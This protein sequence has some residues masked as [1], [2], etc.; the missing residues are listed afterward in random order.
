MKTTIQSENKVTLY[1]ATHNK[2]G[3]KYFG[4][5]TRYFTEEDLQKYYHGSGKYWLRHLYKHGDDITMEIYGIYNLNEVKEEAL[6]LSK[7]WDIVESKDWANLKYEDGLNGGGNII[8]DEGK[9][10]ISLANSDKLIVINEEGKNIKISTS[11]EKYING[12]YESVN[13]GKLQVYNKIT[14]ERKSI[15]VEDFDRTKYN[16]YSFNKVSCIVDGKNKLIS[17]EVFDKYHYDTATTNKAIVKDEDGNIFSV[18]KDNEKY[19]SGEYVGAMKGTVTVIDE[20]GNYLRV[21]ANHKKVLDGTYK[22]TSTGRKW[23]NNGIIRKTVKEIELK[24]YLCD[25]WFLGKKIKKDK[26]DE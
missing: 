1:I 25:G 10:R 15:K 14:G 24:K 17:K 23:I 4:K 3:L 5:T 18:D 13:K 20:E 6:K 26:K 2:T 9:R 12:I 19:L 11:N 16:H 22:G 8:S 7:S 21:P